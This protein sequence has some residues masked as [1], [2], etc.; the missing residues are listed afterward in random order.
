MH[1]YIGCYTTRSGKPTGASGVSLLSGGGQQLTV[2]PG[3]H[4]VN[5]TYLALTPDNQI[6]YAA[7]ELPD[8]G[9]IAAFRRAGDTL[10]PLGTP[11]L[12][13]GTRSCY[14]SV[15]PAGY[16]LSA[17]YGHGSLA[18]HPTG[19]DGAL[20]E[21][22]DLVRLTGSGP[23]PDRQEAAHAHMIVPTPDSQH[24]LAIDLGTDSIYRYTLA[25][26]RLQEDAVVRIAPGAGPR[27]LAYH[28]TLPYAYVAN[29]L[30]STVSVLDLAGF[31]VGATTSTVEAD[32]DGTSHPSAIR[33][34]PD[35][36]FCYV[37]NRGVD[38][39]AVLAIHP[40][41][42]TLELITTVP[43]GGEHPRDM[44]LAG[45]YL[46]SANQFSNTITQFH[47]DQRTGVPR[48]LGEP[49]P[50]SAPSCLVFAA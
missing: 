22:T 32:A 44:T 33:V 10:A 7:V 12:T 23:D 46:Y 1:G 27:H 9:A 6:L 42:T 24:V 15:H 39:I 34:S 16:V 20:L 30:N 5:P 13:G 31:S 8:G 11:R 40:D 43:C 26:G 48:Q 36:R 49:V 41:G 28:P 47:V 35:G 19:G 3:P 14:V 17:D 25:S 29:E 38:T 2:R 45:E 21:R 18:V 50:T 4:A 37:A